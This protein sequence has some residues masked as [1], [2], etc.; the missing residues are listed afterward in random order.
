MHNCGHSDDAGV[1]C[2]SNTVNVSSTSSA[3]VVSILEFKALY[4]LSEITNEVQ[5][6]MTLAVAHT[7]NIDA[8][9]IVLS[10]TDIILR[11]RKLLQQHGVLVNVGVQNFQGSVS[12]LVSLLTQESINSHMAAQGLRPVQIVITP[13]I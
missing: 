11:R 9:N 7:C 13:G 6:K 4:L 12:A 3:V 5:D 10:F 8:G 1:C 2:K